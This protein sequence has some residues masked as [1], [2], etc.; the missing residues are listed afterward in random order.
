M[1]QD[2]LISREQGKIKKQEPTSYSSQHSKV[3][4][5]IHI[6]YRDEM[7]TFFFILLFKKMT[8]RRT[9]KVTMILK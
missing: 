5:T 3:A 8:T 6:K 4:R 1:W 7:R 2:V 9:S